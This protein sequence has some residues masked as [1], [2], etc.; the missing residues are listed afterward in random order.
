MR[1]VGDGKFTLKIGGML[2][3]EIGVKWEVSIKEV[4]DINT[5]YMNNIGNYIYRITKQPTPAVASGHGRRQL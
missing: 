1:E 5:N 3:S 2:A 4:G